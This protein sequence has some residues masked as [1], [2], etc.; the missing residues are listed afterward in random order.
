MKKKSFC[1]QVS[2]ASHAH[3]YTDDN[4]EKKEDEQSLLLLSSQKKKR[5]RK[6]CHAPASG[7]VRSTRQKLDFL[8]I[9]QRNTVTFWNETSR[10]RIWA[11]EFCL[12]NTFCLPLLFVYRE[13]RTAKKRDSSRLYRSSSRRETINYYIKLRIRLSSDAS[14]GQIN[15]AV[16]SRRSTLRQGAH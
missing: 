8:V 10:L 12:H 2:K 13:P 1:V 9:A 14:F 6:K 15:A 3:D 11:N 4:E 7:F 16:L 5:K